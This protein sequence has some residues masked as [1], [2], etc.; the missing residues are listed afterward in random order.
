[1]LGFFMGLEFIEIVVL[2]VDGFGLIISNYTIEVEC[3]PKLMVK[4]IIV[5]LGGKYDAGR[6]IG[7]YRSLHIFLIGAQK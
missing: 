7:I 1:M 6:I 2:L 4:L 3:D 5:H